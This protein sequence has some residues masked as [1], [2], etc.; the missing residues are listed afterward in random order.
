MA[1]T[2]RTPSRQREA[3]A[4][5]HDVRGFTLVELVFVAALIALLST[6]LYGSV[7]G[8]VR[9][10]NKLE[11]RRMIDRTAQYV[12]GRMTRE[13]TNAVPVPF[14]TYQSGT[15]SSDSSSDKNQTKTY[16]LGTKGR[17][18]EYEADVLRFTSAGS[19]QVVFEGSSNFGVVE[20]E[21]RLEQAAATALMTTDPAKIPEGEVRTVLVRDEIPAE[22]KDKDTALARRV[23]FPLSEN[24]VSLNF[25]FRRAEKWLD[26]W[27]AK[28]Q[29]YPGAV[30]IT[31][32][33]RGEDGQVESFRTA[34]AM[35]REEDI[36][37]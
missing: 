10:K 14:T 21:Y 37:P 12:L 5:W 36:V 15:S 4:R 9:T 2:D 17:I 24:V 6:I 28:R 32:G 31:I 16:F 7:G 25:R 20:V 34:V 26:E 27:P 29:G 22:V 8:I 35:Q 33:V 19:G 30:E 13:L 3:R 1:Q 23:V 18:G 11:S